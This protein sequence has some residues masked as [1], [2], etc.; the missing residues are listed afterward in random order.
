MRMTNLT[1]QRSCAGAEGDC[2]DVPA[3]TLCSPLP[4][5]TYSEAPLSA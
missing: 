3:R 2:N 4:T 1:L 5:L